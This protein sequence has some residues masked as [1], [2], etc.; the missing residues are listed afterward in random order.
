M[1]SSLTKFSKFQGRPWNGLPRLS[2]M[3]RYIAAELSLPFLFGVG[4]FS[5]IAL[6]V[7]ALFDLIRRIA[8]YGLPLQLAIEILLLKAPEFIVYSFPMSALLA[9]LM[10][11]SRLSTDSEL[12]ALRGCGVS[13]YRLVA[14][15]I[16]LCFFVTG[17]TFTFNELLVPAASYRGTN[18]LE[19]ALGEVRP[20]FQDENVLYEEYQTIQHR[21][22]GREKVLR[23][24]FYAREFDGQEMKG[25]TI[26]DFSREGLDQI[27]SAKSAV[28]NFDQNLWEFSNGTIYGISPDGSF[29]NIATFEDQKL[30]LPRTPL[31]LASRRRD[32]NEMNIAQALEY[33]RLLTNEGSDRKLRELRI[34]IHQKVALPFI[35]IAFGLVG[36]A[37]GATLRN[38]GRA[39]SFAA[40]VVIIFGYYLTAFTT[41]AIAQ[42]G[43]LSPFLG[44]W[45]PNLFGFAAGA[46]LLVRAAR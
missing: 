36:A 8:E 42:V 24:I 15:A 30:Q 11:Y 43:L 10:T 18:L 35:C 7:G 44:A 31:D 28:W 2:V 21:G 25:L 39:T 33:K 46:F 19:T 17:L 22:G 4:A 3:D 20:N 13:V 41:G 5:S 16:I 14:P 45:L 23:R 34:R 26:L 9:T 29:R 27:I 12:V 37:L 40:S 32:Y 6:S 1:A 38:T